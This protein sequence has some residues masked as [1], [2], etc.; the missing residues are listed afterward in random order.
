MP[1]IKRITA[2]QVADGQVFAS[3]AAAR[4]YVAYQALDALR[5]FNHA[6]INTVLK[7][8]KTLVEILAPLVEAAELEADASSKEPK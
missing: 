5:I 4:H 8:A 1:K 6:S 2:F 3:E 7:E